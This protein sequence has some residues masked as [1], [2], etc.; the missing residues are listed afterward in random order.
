MK[1]IF[2]FMTGL[3]L[4]SSPVFAQKLGSFSNPNASGTAGAFAVYTPQEIQQ[5]EEAGQDETV[6]VQ[7]VGERERGQRTR[8]RP[9]FWVLSGGQPTLQEEDEMYGSLSNDSEQDIAKEENKK[10]AYSEAKQENEEQDTGC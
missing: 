6:S 9:N 10:D 2:V 1:K 8:R 3:M 7:N 5:L 4:F